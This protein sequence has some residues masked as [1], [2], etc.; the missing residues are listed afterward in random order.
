MKKKFSKIPNTEFQFIDKLESWQPK[1]V[2][3][4]VTHILMDIWESYYL[5]FYRFWLLQSI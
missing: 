5:I 4:I 1:T 3:I 2:M